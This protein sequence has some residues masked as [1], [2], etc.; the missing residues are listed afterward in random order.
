MS[1]RASLYRRC[2]LQPAVG[3]RSHL[4]LLQP[5]MNAAAAKTS[6]SR[7]SRRK[8]VRRG[9]TKAVRVKKTSLELACQD[10]YKSGR[11]ACRERVCQYLRI[12]VA[13]VTIKKKQK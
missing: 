1:S 13:A 4:K 6:E 3:S 9:K 8:P 7:A 2:A 5:A 12:L 10:D 11:A